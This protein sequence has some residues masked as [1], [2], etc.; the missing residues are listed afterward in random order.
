MIY[1]QI[2]PYMGEW[3]LYIPQYTREVKLNLVKTI[4]KATFF[5]LFD[6]HVGIINRFPN[7]SVINNVI[8]VYYYYYCMYEPIL[9][10][11]YL[12]FFF[13]SFVLLF[14]RSL[15]AFIFK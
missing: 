6:F 14:Y 3:M 5:M 12:L 13:L 4:L 2:R 8:I 15:F 7:G 9:I 10:I 1:T 11:C